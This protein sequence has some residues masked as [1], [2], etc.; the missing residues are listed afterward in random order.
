MNE[1]ALLPRPIARDSTRRPITMD[2]ALELQAQGAFEGQRTQLLDGEIHVMP[3]DGLRDI[4]YAMEIARACFSALSRERY[5]V[6]V[7]TSLH[8]SRYNGPSPD[9]Y[10]LTAGPLVKETPPE[11]IL[12]VVEVADTSLRADLTDSASRYARHG[13]REFWVVDVDNR[14]THVH[15]A[16]KDGAYPAPQRVA[17][18]NELRPQFIDGFAVR[19]ADFD[20]PVT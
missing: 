14:M 5:F 20:P 2:E 17:F 3:H 8:L 11:R 4:N 19:L 10:V 15:S 13:V 9:I 6:G 18:E 7:Q 12:L 16:P 1:T